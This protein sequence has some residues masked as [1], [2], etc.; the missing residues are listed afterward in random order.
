[1]NFCVV[2]VTLADRLH[3]RIKALICSSVPI[4]H[5]EISQCSTLQPTC[6][7]GADWR[8]LPN[9]N[10]GQSWG[11]PFHPRDPKRSLFGTVPSLSQD[12]GVCK[13]K[14]FDT[15]LLEVAVIPILSTR[16]LRGVLRSLGR[17]DQHIVDVHDYHAADRSTV[18]LDGPE[19]GFT[20]HEHRAAVDGQ[21]G[22]V[23]PPL[24]GSMIETKTSLEKL[25]HFT[26]FQPACFHDHFRRARQKKKNRRP[27]APWRLAATASALQA[28][29]PKLANRAKIFCFA[30]LQETDASDRRRSAWIRE[31]HDHQTR[32]G[33]LPVGL[34]LVSFPRQYQTT[35]QIRLAVSQLSAS[36]FM[37]PFM[38][39]WSSR[40]SLR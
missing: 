13:L 24:P 19:G 5:V 29:Q 30:L 9:L 36:S 23:L 15:A 17:R 10:A 38:R 39:V 7:Q 18:P 4:V 26:C 8:V 28:R 14:N 22:D 40:L 31:S 35:S 32:L 6:S 27:S 3:T 33:L 1:M 11:L 21:A 20:G 25:Q 12:S 37:A 34:G 2:I 16:W